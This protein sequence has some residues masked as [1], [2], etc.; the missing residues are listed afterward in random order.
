[1]GITYTTGAVDWGYKPSGYAAGEGTLLT[2]NTSGGGA[3]G[4][5]SSFK[6]VGIVM[7][8]FG[9]V[10]GAIGSYYAAK[11]QQYQLESQASSLRFQKHLADLNANMAENQA[12]AIM[13]SGNQQIGQLTMRVGKVA[14]SFKASTAARGID[15]HDVGGSYGESQVT[16]ELT[17]QID[18]LT[19][20][21]NTVRAASAARMQKVNYENQGTLLSVSANNAM[22][23]ADSISAGTAAATNLMTGAGTVAASWYQDRKLAAM[24]AKLGIDI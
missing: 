9:L 22:M 16:T 10:S 3:P 1:M 23:S 6:N 12:E 18:M 15:V 21:A 13:H 7:Q 2:G 14:S 24:A 20:N 5:I 8:V 11:T 19:L 4:A 17:K